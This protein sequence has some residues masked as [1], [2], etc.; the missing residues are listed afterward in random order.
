MG[1][2]TTKINPVFWCTKLQL[3]DFNNFKSPGDILLFVMTRS[4]HNNIKE[5]F[6][7]TSTHEHHVVQ[8]V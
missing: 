2:M 5:G 4:N 6:N 1:R 3:S 7:F 8:E